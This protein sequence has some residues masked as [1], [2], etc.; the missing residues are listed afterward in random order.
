MVWLTMLA[1]AFGYAIA[2]LVLTEI[3]K[4]NSFIAAVIIAFPIMTVLTIANLY[5]E[6]G[7]P[8]PAYKLAY[9]TFWLI[10]AS[11]SFFVVLYACQSAGFSFWFGFS[12]AV[13]ATIASIIGLTFLLRQLGINLLSNV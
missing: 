13:V 8:G 9:T 3:A 11:L 1:K 12:I 10:I 4:R 2:I 7:D 6:T 5:L